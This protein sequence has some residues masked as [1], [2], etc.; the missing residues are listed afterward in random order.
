[1]PR[2]L[3]IRRRSPIA[4]DAELAGNVSTL[5][6]QGEDSYEQADGGDEQDQNAV[7]EGGAALRAGSGGTLIAH[8]ATLRVNVCDGQ[9]YYGRAE[10]QQ[11]RHTN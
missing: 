10:T 6:N 4:V 5:V 8:G 7:A 1:M 3:G 11:H 9:R 2:E